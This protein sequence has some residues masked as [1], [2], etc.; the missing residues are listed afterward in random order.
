MA[1]AKAKLR[2]LE[3]LRKFAS[4]L[5]WQFFATFLFSFLSFFVFRNFV[6]SL[7]AFSVYIQSFFI[8]SASVGQAFGRLDSREYEVGHNHEF[9]RSV[10]RL[11][12]LR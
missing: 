1:N 2:G 5:S 11:Y 6:L 3:K 9:C 12:T 10:V 8:V 7:T 4:H